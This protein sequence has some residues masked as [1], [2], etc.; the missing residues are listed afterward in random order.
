VPGSRTDGVGCGAPQTSRGIVRSFPDVADASQLG[1][2]LPSGIR[3]FGLTPLDQTL[4]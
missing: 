3:G 4:G 2:R 1:L